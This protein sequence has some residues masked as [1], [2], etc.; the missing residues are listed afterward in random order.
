MLVLRPTVSE[1]ELWIIIEEMSGVMYG[2]MVLYVDDIAYFSSEDA[3]LAVHEY[4][5]S[6]WPASDLEWI[7][8]SNSVRHLGVEIGRELRTSENGEVFRVYTIGQAAYVQDLLQAC[9]MTE[10]S[11][12]ALPVPKEWVESAE[13][14][15]P[16][17]YD[18]P[19]LRQAQRLVGEM[20][21]LGTRTRPDLMFVI[22]HAASLVAKRP[23]YVVRLGMRLLSY[24]AGT[25]DL[26]MT[27]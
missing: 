7:T 13:N 5:V 17:D 3:I 4:I 25:S 2:L 15:E 6:E 18:E 21:W 23:S 14:D 12:T 10:V 26:R 11:P 16:E 24:L 19:T 8:E 27:I 20:L 22:T 1:P 9:N